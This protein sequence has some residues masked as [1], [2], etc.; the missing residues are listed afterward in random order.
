VFKQNNKEPLMDC[1]ILFERGLNKAGVILCF[2]SLLIAG[3]AGRIP[4][5]RHLQTMTARTVAE[6][7][8]KHAVDLKAFSSE[9]RVTYFGPAGRLKGTVSLAVQRPGKFR[10]NLMGPHGGVLEAFATNGQTFDLSKMSE[11]RFLYGPATPE[12]LDRL[13]FFAPLHLGPEG[14][15]ELLFGAVS[16]P[17]DATLG[18]DD[19]TGHWLLEWQEKQKSVRVHVDPNKMLMN[20][21]EISISGELVCD[22]TIESR[23]A[24]GLPAQL[25]LKAPRDK[26]QATLKT[27]DIIQNP[28]FGKATF[29]LSPPRGVKPE[30]WGPLAD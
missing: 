21:L 26:V 12:T 29:E 16:V 18:Y 6:A 2:I 13:L 20:R 11:S 22:V 25:N 19:Q 24:M 7:M 9:V 28:T 23:H 4:L 8:H 3:C 5:P 15:V 27:R 17:P 30:Y 14:W 1:L 10:Y